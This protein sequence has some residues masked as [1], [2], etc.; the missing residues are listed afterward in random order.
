MRIYVLIKNAEVRPHGS[1][2]EVI[3]VSTDRK[4]TFNEAAELSHKAV[5]DKSTWN[6]DVYWV[7]VFDDKTGKEIDRLELDSNKRREG[8]FGKIVRDKGSRNQKVTGS[9]T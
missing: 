8:T 6:D 9:W 3:T 2:T 1:Y 7:H 5:N 4:R